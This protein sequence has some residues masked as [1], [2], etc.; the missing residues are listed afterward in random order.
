[1]ENHS[2]SAARTW[3]ARSDRFGGGKCAIDR[4]EGKHGPEQFNHFRFHFVLRGRVTA[5]EGVLSAPGD[6]LRASRKFFSVDQE[7]REGLGVGRTRLDPF[8][9]GSRQ[10]R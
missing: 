2:G 5:F 6:F 3:I 1:M 7:R 8:R 4:S 9:K 10:W